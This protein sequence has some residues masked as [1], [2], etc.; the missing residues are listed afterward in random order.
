MS[1]FILLICIALSLGACSS[2]KY[3]PEKQQ[4]LTKLHYQMG[5]DALNKGLLP[6]A[7]KEL[8]EADKIQP[9]QAKVE[10]ALAYAWRLRG[11]LEKSER[12]YKKALAHEARASTQNNYASLLI[13]MKKYKQA[14][15]LLR[16]ALEDP[17]YP[18]QDLV[19]INLGDALL[20]QG[21][22][23]DAID[24]Y[25]KAQRF[26]PNQIL[27]RMKEAAAYIRFNRLN[28]ARALYETLLRKNKDNRF[29][30]EGLLSVLKK[31]NDLP[32][33]R[34]M[35]KAYRQQSSNDLDKAWAADELAKIR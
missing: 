7:F 28:Y 10:D 12:Y 6:K 20:E 18:N 13:Q 17:R 14:E 8:L 5:I 21:L 34:A 33:A 16:K 24:A 23:N 19:F 2:G 22:F 30:A 1:K 31:Q 4:K 26:R 29:V 35:L 3:T 32:A 15:V 25:R 9:G 11:D 27:P